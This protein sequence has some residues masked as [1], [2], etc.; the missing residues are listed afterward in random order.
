MSVNRLVSVLRVLDTENRLLERADQKAISLL[1]ALDDAVLIDLLD[2]IG[3][4]IC[5]TT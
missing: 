5:V 1:S 2:W 3:H 4:D